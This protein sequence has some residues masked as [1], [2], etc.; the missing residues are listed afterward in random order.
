[1]DQVSSFLEGILTVDASAPVSNPIAGSKSDSIWTGELDFS[2]LWNY[3]KNS[4]SSSKTAGAASGAAGS[5][6]SNRPSTNSSMLTDKLI[7]KMI[8][9]IIPMNVEGEQSSRILSERI[10]MQKFRPQLSMNIMSINSVQFNQRLSAVFYMI[11][12]VIMLM[13]WTSPAYTIGMLLVATHLILNPYLVSVLPVVLLMKNFLVPYYLLIYTPDNSLVPDLLDYNP[14]PAAAALNTY[15]TPGPV[16]QLSREFILNLTDLQNHMVPYIIAYDYFVWLTE[17]Y[18]YYKNENITSVIY[19]ALLALGI[20][21]V[22]FFPK[23]FPYLIRNVLV[24]KLLGIATVWGSVIMF[25]PQVRGRIL[26][27]VYNEDTRLNLLHITDKIEQKLVRALVDLENSSKQGESSKEDQFEDEREVEIFELQKFNKKAKMWELVGFTDNFYTINVASR[28][29]NLLVKSKVSESEDNE[30][31]N[32][33]EI[34]GELIKVNKKKALKDILPPKNWK[35][36]GNK[37]IMDLDTKGWVQQNL[38]E[39]LVMIDDDEKWV[40]DFQEP[41]VLN[42]KT[43]DKAADDKTKTNLSD[44]YRR[45]RWIRVCCR[46]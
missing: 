18:L 32:E 23:I 38:I 34:L 14:I 10:E 22:V 2:S 39:D 33:N 4:E 16:P 12:N 3:G 15:K 26:E 28:K 19:L 1:M 17:D 43:E 35:F 21:N 42:E 6:A 31:T 40:Y 20:N 37:W 46:E 29:Y 11:D 13:N 30:I 24:L 8:L 9:M 5:S 27:W 36:L 44:F 45:R 41:E 7:E 25:H